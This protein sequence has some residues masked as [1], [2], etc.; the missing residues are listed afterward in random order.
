MKGTRRWQPGLVAARPVEAGPARRE[1]TDPSV[2][3]RALT[4]TWPSR[5]K[6]E[7]AGTGFRKRVDGRSRSDASRPSC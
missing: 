6:S 1:T 5:P 7:S 3:P 2:A 4:G